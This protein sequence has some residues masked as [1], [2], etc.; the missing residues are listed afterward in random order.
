[1]LLVGVK[2]TPPLAQADEHDRCHVV[3]RHGEDTKDCRQCFKSMRTQSKR[4]AEKA[5]QESQHRAP[6]I[7]H[8]DSRLRTVEPEEAREGSQERK[9]NTECQFSSRQ[10]T[11]PRRWQPPVEQ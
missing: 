6:A 3:D 4:Q 1:M 9:K 5:Q 2:R 10:K 8:E 11:K 7:S